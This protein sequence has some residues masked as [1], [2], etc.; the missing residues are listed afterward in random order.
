M[1]LGNNT[2]DNLLSRGKSSKDKQGIDST[3][4]N[5]NQMKRHNFDHR[6]VRTSVKYY[7]TSPHMIKRKGRRLVKCFYCKEI[8]YKRHECRIY[9]EDQKVD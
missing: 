6:D 8:R 2:L 4:S 1:I 7:E 3:H 9:I 5:S